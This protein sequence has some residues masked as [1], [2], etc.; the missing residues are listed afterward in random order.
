VKLSNNFILKEWY[1]TK[2]PTGRKVCSL[3]VADCSKPQ[4]HIC[5]EHL[6]RF[7]KN[8]PSNQLGK[9]LQLMTGSD[10]IVGSNIT[11]HFVEIS[12]LNRRPFFRT[13]GPTL[14][15]PS[16]YETYNELAEEITNVINNPKGDTV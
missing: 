4:E 2:M 14:E 1:E 16:T 13:C 3:F 5:L 12:G 6:K 7:T 8:L 10:I 9:F 15:L 11:V